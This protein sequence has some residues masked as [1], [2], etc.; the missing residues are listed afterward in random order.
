MRRTRLFLYCLIGAV[1]VTALG[2]VTNLLTADG[3]WQAMVAPENRWLLF[4]L[5]GLTLLAALVAF[6][7]SAENSDTSSD[8]QN[9][10]VTSLSLSHSQVMQGQANRD[11]YQIQTDAVVIHQPLATGQP[12][13]P[14]TEITN[15]NALLAKVRNAWIKGVLNRSLYSQARIALGLEDRPDMVMHP[16]RMEYNYASQRRPLPTGT[17][18]ITKLQ[19]LGEGA[20]LLILGD[21][22][23]GKTTML[24]ELADDLLH[25]ANPAHPHSPLPVV[26]NLSSWSQ[27]RPTDP[28]Q[29]PNLK[30]WLVQEFKNKYQI[31]EK[32]AQEWIDQQQLMLLLDGLDEVTEARRADCLEAIN[33]FSRNHGTTEMV[34]CCRIRDF[35]ALQ[36]DLQF[37]AAV[38]I[39]PLNPQQVDA[40]L[41]QGGEQLKGIRTVLQLEPELQD[42]DPDSLKCLAET[43][44]FLNIMALAF[45]G[46][47][48]AAIQ[49]LG[50]KNQ[51]QALFDAYIGRMF[52]QRT[53]H[54]RYP[55]ARAKWWLHRLAKQ[56]VQEGQTVFLI[57]Y[58]QPQSWLIKTSERWQNRLIV[59]LIGGLI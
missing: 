43:P 22:G 36:H 41:S 11:N 35:E 4:V 23:S 27:F 45:E 39:K 1:V 9:Q 7:D 13:L 30:G 18:L 59:G 26:F 15:R 28:R 52:N 40:Y 46:R 3:S 56:M 21:P 6:V 57:E 17:R 2:I 50:A 16:W 48:V 25:Q 49:N 32:I 37:Q 20:T 58:M 19:E 24:L 8:L 12:I 33:Q 55:K 34:V 53:N 14:H 47:S 38:Y 29:T 31:P 54:P 42:P 51:R 5:I 10:A 44:L